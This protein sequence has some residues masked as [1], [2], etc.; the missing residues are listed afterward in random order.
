MESRAMILRAALPL[1]GLVCALSGAAACASTRAQ[2][3]TDPTPLEIPEPPPRLIEPL[4]EVAEIPTPE[5]ERR[6]SVPP[7]PRPAPRG[8]DVAQANRSEPKPE[9]AKPPDPPIPAVEP[10]AP[11]PPRAELRTPDTVDDQAV[12]QILE[13]AKKMLDRVDY[14]KLG[15]EGQEQY[16][17][18]MR[19]RQ[20]A[21]EALS[22]R[23]QIAAKYLADKA[24]KIA[25]EL[26]GR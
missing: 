14:R 4:P 10:P 25:K 23:N 9:A 26:T 19:F 21:Q 20:Q 12:N 6:E 8:R 16:D 3:R 2:T 17:T 5:P 1:V 7:L 11:S 18:A 22:A 24:E 15:K 13:S